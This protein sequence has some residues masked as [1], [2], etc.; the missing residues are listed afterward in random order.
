MLVCQITLV[1]GKIE[2]L[3]SQQVLHE[4]IY[5]MLL[6]TYKDTTNNVING[7]AFSDMMYFEQAGVSIDVASEFDVLTSKDF[8]DVM[9]YLNFHYQVAHT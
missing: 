4:L 1:I 8:S 5:D 9:G 2:S 3:D 7:F 6:L